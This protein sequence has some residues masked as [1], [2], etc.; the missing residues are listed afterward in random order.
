MSNGDFLVRGATL[1]CS[2]G[3]HKRRINLPKCHG[4]YVGM[5]PLL[6]E[7]ECLSEPFCDRET[8]NIT[9][10]GVCV[11]TEGCPPTEVKIYKKTK[12]N[13]K[14]GKV[15]TVEGYQCMPTIVGKWMNTYRDTRIIDNGD[16]SS[17]R[18]LMDVGRELPYGQS[19]LTTH[20]YLVCKYGGIISPVDSGQ[21]TEV[22]ENEF[23][24]PDDFLTLQSM[25][26]Q[27]DGYRFDGTY[28]K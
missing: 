8:C 7:L 3:S 6:H 18:T 27:Q 2:N 1:I 10:F 13:S 15:G 28:T 21:N 26:E 20:S 11:P 19:T 4:V 25:D 24:S 9:P 17:D 5:H 14:D 23:Y 12:N 22:L 16:K